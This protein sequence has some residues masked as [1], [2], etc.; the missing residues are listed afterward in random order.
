MASHQEANKNI[1]DVQALW[2][3]NDE[4]MQIAE[5]AYRTWLEGAET[6]QSQALD[7]WNNGL[8]KGVDAMN[9]IAKCQTAAEAFG[10]QTRY[11][12]EAMQGLF[13]EGQKVMDQLTT[14]TKTPW[15]TTALVP[16]THAEPAAG[17]GHQS[18][19]PRATRRASK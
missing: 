18:E 12:T 9:Q 11:A 19:K 14:F 4:T 8:Q 15:A 17:N 5:R 6:I 10:V 1:P 7:F 2:G 3:W 16:R 13:A